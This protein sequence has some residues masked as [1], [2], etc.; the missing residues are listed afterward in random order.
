MLTCEADPRGQH[1]LLKLD[2]ILFHKEH[3]QPMLK[4]LPYPE[5][6]PLH[7]AITSFHLN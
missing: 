7:L 5:N 6:E 4:N 3:I 1:V 2:G